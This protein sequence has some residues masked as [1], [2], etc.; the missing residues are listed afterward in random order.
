MCTN[1]YFIHGP[2]NSRRFAF[3]SKTGEVMRTELLRFQAKP[4]EL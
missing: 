2:E 1:L 4:D 3:N